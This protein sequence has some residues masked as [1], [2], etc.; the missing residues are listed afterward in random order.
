MALARSN[1]RLC[2]AADRPSP[3][4][5]HTLH[6]TLFS[7][8][9]YIQVFD[10]VTMSG[11]D[12]SSTM[13]DRHSDPIYSVQ[14]SS[15]GRA[16]VRTKAGAFSMIYVVQSKD[17]TGTREATSGQHRTLIPPQQSR[18]RAQPTRSLHCFRPWSVSPRVIDSSGGSCRVIVE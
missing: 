13:Y 7:R 12:H 16:S 15:G 3:W 5:N 6:I 11:L 17:P 2:S 8:A 4:Y 1:D 10:P 14:R 18:Q 9:L